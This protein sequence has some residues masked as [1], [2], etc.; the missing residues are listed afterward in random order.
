M[1]QPEPAPA[2]RQRHLSTQLTLAALGALL[3]VVVHFTL[4]KS[5]GQSFFESVSHLQGHGWPFA[6]MHFV[7]SYYM[8]LAVFLGMVL[9]AVYRRGPRA[10]VFAFFSG[11]AVPELLIFHWLK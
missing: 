6:W 4:P 5:P 8:Q 10:W 2:D 7:V 1:N 11:G 3:S 9:F